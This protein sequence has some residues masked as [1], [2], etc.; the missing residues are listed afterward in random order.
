MVFWLW[1]IL[2]IK[3]ILELTLFW[4]YPFGLAPF[5]LQLGP[6]NLLPYTSIGLGP[7]HLC[8]LE[9]EYGNSNV[10]W[11]VQVHTSVK[12]CLLLQVICNLKLLWSCFPSLLFTSTIDNL[13]ISKLKCIYWCLLCGLSGSSWLLKIC[14]RYLL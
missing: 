9:V 5:S 8:L 2:L 1:R 12:L 7:S 10:V 4:S 14:M 6:L 3:G 13:H 11:V